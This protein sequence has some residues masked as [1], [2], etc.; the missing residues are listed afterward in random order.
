VA[1]QQAILFVLQ[2]L[3]LLTKSLADKTGECL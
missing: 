3:S 1:S 2:A